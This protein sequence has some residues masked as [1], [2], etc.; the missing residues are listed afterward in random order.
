MAITKTT[1]E[2]PCPLFTGRGL[3]QRGYTIKSPYKT[4]LTTEPSNISSERCLV[5][6]FNYDLA[7][8]V[9]NQTADVRGFGVYCETGAETDAIT[10][11]KH[12]YAVD[13]YLKVS[14]DYNLGPGEQHNCD[15]RAGSMRIETQIVFQV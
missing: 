10:D 6:V 1:A 14:E 8:Y 7:E 5:T 12:I 4:Y 11:G 9:K 2:A 13:F 15:V 3:E